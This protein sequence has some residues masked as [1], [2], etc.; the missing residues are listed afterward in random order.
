VNLNF[1]LQPI[2]YALALTALF[3]IGKGIVISWRRENAVTPVI[4]ETALRIL[5]QQTQPMRSITL[6]GR[7]EEE[8]HDEDIGFSTFHRAIDKLVDRGEVVRTITD[9]ESDHPKTWFSCP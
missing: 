4:Q 7:L 9:R 5:K 3:Y 8:L 2:L 6:F 1:G